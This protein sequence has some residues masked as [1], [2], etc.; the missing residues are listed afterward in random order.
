MAAVLRFIW[1]HAAL[2][3]CAAGVASA[4]MAQGGAAPAASAPPSAETGRAL[5][6]AHCARCHGADARGSAQGPDLRERVRGMSRDAFVSAVL[7]RYRWTM[8]AT[9]AGG[10]SEAREA[11]VRGVLEP[12]NGS[13]GMPAWQ[14]QPEVAQGVQS[15][16]EHLNTVS[17]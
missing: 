3:L 8:P 4:A 13:G 5:F 11:L 15:L 7:R 9:S 6:A 2:A 14:D 12:R 16:Y 10:E 17:R 1:G